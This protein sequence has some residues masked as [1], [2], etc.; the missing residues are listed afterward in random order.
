MIE[1]YK[2][3]QTIIPKISDWKKSVLKYEE[4]KDWRELSE[5]FSIAVLRLLR[6]NDKN[7][8]WL[9]K[10]LGTKPQY[11]SRLVKGTENLSLKTIVKIQ[12]I[13]DEEIINIKNI[14]KPDTKYLIIFVESDYKEISMNKTPAIE[15]KIKDNF[16]FTIN[17]DYTLIHRVV[18]DAEFVEI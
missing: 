8:V 2:D 10:E 6:K 17:R 11:V 18:E 13:F 15:N 3:T 5:Q 16:Y 7:K 14:D 12:S 4:E 1:K 9:A